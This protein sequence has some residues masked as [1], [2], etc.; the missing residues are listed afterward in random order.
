MVT[1]ILILAQLERARR[2]TARQRAVH[3]QQV[4]QQVQ[5]LARRP[6]VAARPSAGRPT[7][8]PLTERQRNNRAAAARQSSFTGFMANLN[9][10]L[11]VGDEMAAG[12][13]AAYEVASGRSKVRNLQDA[14]DIFLANL[15]YQRALEDA[16]MARH[17][18][19]AGLARG[20][21]DAVVTAIPGGLGAK[22]LIKVNQVGAPM[23]ARLVTAG[24]NAARGSVAFGISSAAAGLADRGNSQERL[25]AALENAKRASAV[26]AV[27]GPAAGI[28]AAPR[29]PLPRDPS[30]PV[31]PYESNHGL[32]KSL[33]TRADNYGNRK[34][35]LTGPVAGTKKH[36]YAEQLLKRYQRRYGNRDL[37]PEA[38]YLNKEPWES[39]RTTRGSVRLDVVERWLDEP[40]HVWDYKFGGAKLTASRETQIRRTIPYGDDT[41]VREVRP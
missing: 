2:E 14:R 41:L 3:N 8:P 20:A 9:R 34:D 1:P 31:D 24:G 21:G 36:Y 7:P 37:W 17:P 29:K 32:I 15:D 35:W 26:G 12:L 33:A 38:R 6:V 11:V 27:F 4:A 30:L 39:G 5:A 19:W 25:T 23:T 10:G 13:G 28:V 18:M 22:T 40:T 16:Y